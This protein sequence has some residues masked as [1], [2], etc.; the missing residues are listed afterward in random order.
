[1]IAKLG[2][3][4]G[5]IMIALVLLAMTTL[6]AQAH[7]ISASLVKSDRQQCERSAGNR[8]AL[9]NLSARAATANDVEA[10]LFS[11]VIGE[12]AQL[13][14]AGLIGA[15][16]AEATAQRALSVEYAKQEPPRLAYQLP[17]NLRQ[18]A[19]FSCIKAFPSSNPW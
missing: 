11:T 19:H 12:K 8:V 6:V 10:G 7:L 16:Q 18:Y 9:I 15:R 5:L 1:M 17:P 3:A 14:V 13:A 2:S 4:R